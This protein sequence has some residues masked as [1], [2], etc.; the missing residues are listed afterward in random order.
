M[1]RSAC[2]GGHFK[3]LTVYF[4]VKGNLTDCLK[5]SFWELL[6]LIP[7]NLIFCELKFFE[8]YFLELTG[9]LIIYCCVWSSAIGIKLSI[10]YS[11]KCHGKVPG[12]VNGMLDFVEDLSK[13]VDSH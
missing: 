3:D 12:L 2:Q 9:R 8:T 7:G 11:I 4:E 13:G 1:R 5:A 6:G 10:I